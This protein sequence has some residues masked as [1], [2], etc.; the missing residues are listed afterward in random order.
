MQT[1]IYGNDCTR[2]S[3][4]HISLCHNKTWY[5]PC[6]NEC[7]KNRRTKSLMII[8]SSHVESPYLQCCTC[9]YKAN[10]H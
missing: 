4:T 8:I 1:C 7:R 9:G 5:R 2:V 3:K 10:Y 6:C